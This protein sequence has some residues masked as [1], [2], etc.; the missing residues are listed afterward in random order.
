MQGGAG[1]VAQRVQP[2]A[3]MSASSIGR[4]VQ[5]PVPARFFG[6]GEECAREQN[7]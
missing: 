6:W 7:C 1:T 3:V 2:Q 4:L 5:V